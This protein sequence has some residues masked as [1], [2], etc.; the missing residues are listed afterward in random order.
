MSV[1]S[2]LRALLAGDEVG[3]ITSNRIYPMRAP[4]DG[5]RPHVQFHRT[6]GGKDYCMS[7][8]VPDQGSLWQFDCYAD[9]HKDACDLANA[10][11]EKLS[12]FRGTV[13]YLE[14]GQQ[15][16]L[17]VQGI[18]IVEDFDALE[19]PDNGKDEAI[20]WVPVGAQVWVRK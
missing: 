16:Q 14:N 11:K 8:E 19:P 15:K 6:A 3:R 10:V 4:Q 18:F 17:K 5:T 20:Y 9:R 2:G 7:G 12:A 13:R 1:D